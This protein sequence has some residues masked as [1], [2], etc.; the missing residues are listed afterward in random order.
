MNKLFTL[1][2][3]LI[4][5]VSVDAFSAGVLVISPKTL[6]F[7]AV[8]CGKEKCLDLTFTNSGDTDLSITT[9]DLMLALP[10]K[11][12]NAVDLPMVIKPTESKSITLCFAPETAPKD[13]QMVV[14]VK[15]DDNK[16][17]NYTLKGVSKSPFIMF[18]KP[19]VDM[20]TVDID[21]A[22]N[23]NFEITNVGDTTLTLTWAQTGSTQFTCTPVSSG[24]KELA[25][26][27]KLTFNVQFKPQNLGVIAAKL[28][29]TH[30][31]C[32]QEAI[33][34]P[35]I[36]YG[37]DP[38]ALGPILQV[39]FN[40]FDT[41]F[42]KTKKCQEMTLRNIGDTLL[43]V[44]STTGFPAP[45]SG[46]ITTPLT[47]MPGATNKINVCYTPQNA[48]G[49]DSA[50]ITMNADSRAPMSIAL[51]YD[52]SGS[53][54]T[55]L[56]AVTRIQAAH[57]AGVDF[58]NGLLDLEGLQDEASVFS[59]EHFSNFQQ[60]IGFTT[61]KAALKNAVPISSPGAYTCFYNGLAHT[62][63]SVIARPKRKAIIALTDGEDNCPDGTYNHINVAQMAKDA[64]IPIFTVGIGSADATILSYIA[65]QTGGSYFTAD[66]NSD[67]IQVYR[68]IAT[69][70]SKNVDLAF[71]LHGESVVP[72]LTTTPTSIAFDSVKVGQ[73]ICRDVTVKNIGNAP[74]D[75]KQF[76]NNN[77]QY[78]LKNTTVTDLKP[79]ET[80]EFI[81]CVAPDRLRMIRDTIN[82]VYRGCDM[83]TVGLPVSAIGWDSVTIYTN[84][85]LVAKPGT[86]VRL[87]IYL[88]DKLPAIYETDQ[89]TIAFK[90][91]KT[92]LYP[93]DLPA[94]LANTLSA[95]MVQGDVFKTFSSDSS[96]I[97]YA[98]AGKTLEALVNDSL[99]LNTDFLALHG[100]AMTTGLRISKCK[101]ADG[102]PKVG[103]V[104]A[105][106]FRADSLC[107]HESRLID[108]SARIG[109]L[110]S[111]IYSNQSGSLEVN[112]D[113][114]QS[115]DI[116]VEMYDVL[117]NAVL[118]QK[119]LNLPI[120]ESKVAWRLAELSNGAYIVRI[121]MGGKTSSQLIMINK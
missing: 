1:F 7:G 41:T 74:L 121:S 115:A 66:N 68:Q 20:D 40:D 118:E 39:S 103:I 33:E 119:T 31:S 56:G 45:F 98:I 14:Y 22:K 95:G 73:T 71:T 72:V 97:E 57:D 55:K 2:V 67:L 111:V 36:G 85:H 64:G 63:T 52:V 69:L 21:A 86:V 4:A 38:N 70:L 49:L 109:K 24:I 12:G 80:T 94:Q 65:N 110:K 113:L 107:Y 108:A 99:L 50:V 35:F 26:G 29:F 23:D 17:S 43:T 44:H 87:P 27:E 34:M 83:E 48:P 90:Y 9:V 5:L 19:I 18:S 101:F 58:L 15:Y 79:N 82:L 10:F 93:T 78:S 51:L 84:A 62:L 6:D 46:A 54:Q 91:N 13:V 59:F 96:E 61:D 8:M 76:L 116:S 25:V 3:F 11:L 102:N 120:G 60:L 114:V 77:T 47:L 16:E 117:G 53:M 106:D 88:K 89:Y 104:N 100:N 37:R 28:V 81:V 75:V 105:S 112:C 32:T 42:C 92:M 30:N